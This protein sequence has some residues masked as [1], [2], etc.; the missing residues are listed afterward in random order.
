IQTGTLATSSTSDSRITENGTLK[1]APNP[2]TGSAVTIEY[3]LADASQ[4]ASIV[5]TDNFGQAA[6][7]RNVVLQQGVNRLTINTGS[8]KP[9]IYNV[10]IRLGASGKTTSKKLLIVK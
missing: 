9:G 7:Q 1:L 10:T 3:T 6:Q 8:L 4:P 2:A 5:V